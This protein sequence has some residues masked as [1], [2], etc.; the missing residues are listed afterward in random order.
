MPVVDSARSN[1]DDNAA[2]VRQ[3]PLI[4]RY[5]CRTYSHLVAADRILLDPPSQQSSRSRRHTSCRTLGWSRLQRA[6]CQDIDNTTTSI[7][8]VRVYLLLSRS[9][10]VPIRR[11]RATRSYSPPLVDPA[12]GASSCGGLPAPSSLE[13]HCSAGV[14]CRRGSLR[15]CSRILNCEIAVIPSSPDYGSKEVL[16]KH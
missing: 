3:H 4:R 11:T 5:S 13:G 1:R 15:A 2:R 9:S 12:R 14:R 10:N 16:V 6:C 7:S 8:T